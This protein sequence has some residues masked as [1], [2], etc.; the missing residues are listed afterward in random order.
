MAGNN[1]SLPKSFC[2]C[3]KSIFVR[4][5]KEEFVRKCNI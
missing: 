3:E 5:I 1:N 2:D 4:G